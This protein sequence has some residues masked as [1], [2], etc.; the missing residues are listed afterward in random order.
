MATGSRMFLWVIRSPCCCLQVSVSVPV[1]P[2][3][4]AKALDVVVGK[5]RLKVGLKGQPPIIDVGRRGV[6]LYHHAL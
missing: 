5:T 2:G 4:K 1:P 3:T 6:L